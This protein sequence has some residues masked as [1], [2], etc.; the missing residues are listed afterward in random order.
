MRVRGPDSDG[1][2]VLSHSR[3]CGDSAPSAGWTRAPRRA[4]LAARPHSGASPQVWNDAFCSLRVVNVAGMELCKF[5]F[6]D[7]RLALENDSKRDEDDPP[8]RRRVADAKT[9]R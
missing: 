5:D 3:Q 2:D 1:G 9:E 8:P 7:A 6:L 4:G